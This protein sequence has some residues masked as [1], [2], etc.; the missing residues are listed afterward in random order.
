MKELRNPNYKGHW[1]PRQ[2]PNPKNKVAETAE[3]LESAEAV[4]F[5]FKL[6]RGKV[7]ISNIRINVIQ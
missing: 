1:S 2:I 5:A 6:E 4:G 3:L 7:F